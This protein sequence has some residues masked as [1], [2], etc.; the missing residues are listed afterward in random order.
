MFRPTFRRS[1]EGALILEDTSAA[2]VFNSLR[3]R[4]TGK[5][6]TPDDVRQDALK[7]VCRLGGNTKD[8]CDVLGCYKFQHSKYSGQTFKWMVENVLEYAVCFVIKMANEIPST[9]SLSINKFN[10]K[11]YLESF[12]EGKEAIAMKEIKRCRKCP[13]RQTSYIPVG[14]KLQKVEDVTDETLSGTDVFDAS[15]QPSTSYAPAQPNTSYEPVSTMPSTTITIK[16]S[17]DCLIPDKWK[18]NLP[19]IDQQ[20]ISKTLFKKSKKGTAELDSTKLKQL[21]YYPPQPDPLNKN[22]PMANSYFGHRLLLWLPRKTWQVKLVCPRPECKSYP[23]TSGGLHGIV[24]PVL[25]LDCHYFLATEQLRCSNCKQRQIGWSENIL[26]QLDLA[27]RLQFPVVLSYHLACDNRVLQLLKYRGLGNSPSQLR[28]QVLEQHTRRWNERV[29]LYLEN[30]KKFCG[31]RDDYV[32]AASKFDE[33]SKMIP[34][35]SVQWFL[36]IY[37][38][39][40]MGRIDELKASITSTFGRVLKIDSTKRIVRKLAGRACGTGAWATNV[41]NEYGQV[42]ITVLTAAEGCG[43]NNMTNGI[44]NRYALAGVPPPEILYVDRDCCGHSSIRKMFSAWPDMKIRLDIWHFMRRIAA[45]CST[46]S[47]QLYP[48]FLKR[49]SACI[50]EWSADDVELLKL[51]KREQLIASKK[52]SN[53][54][55][56]IILKNISKKEYALHCRRTTRGTRETANLIRELLTSL[57]GEEGRDTMGVPLLDSEQTWDIWSSQERHIA[58]IQDPEGI[59]LYTKTSEMLKGGVTL[60]VYRCARGSTSLESFHLHLNR[61]IPGERASDLHFQAYLMDGLVRWNANRALAA[62]QSG[63]PIS[64]TY[65]GLHQHALNILAEQVIGKKVYKSFIIPNKYTGEL[66]GVEYLY[67]QS[68]KVLE[69]QFPVKTDTIYDEDFDEEIYTFDVDEGY[70]DKTQPD[71]K[72]PK[73]CFKPRNAK[74]P[75]PPQLEPLPSCDDNDDD[76]QGKAALFDTELEDSTGP[77]NIPGYAKVEAMADY[78]MQFKED[79]GVISQSHAEH[80]AKLW[81]NLDAYDKTIKR[82]ARHQDYL[83]KG[84]FK[85]SKTT[86]VIPGVESTRRCFLGQN[87]GPAQWPDCNRYMECIITKLCEAYPSTVSIEGR[88]FQRWPLITKG[89]KNIRRKVLSNGHLML[90]AK[91]QLMEINRTTLIQWYNRTSK[92]QERQVLESGISAT[93]PKLVSDKTLLEPLTKPAVLNVHTSAPSFTFVLPKNTS[94]LATQGNRPSI[95]VPG[96]IA[97]PPPSVPEASSTRIPRTTLLYRKRVAKDISE[98]KPIKIYKPRTSAIVCSKCKQPRLNKNHTQYYGNWYCAAT[99]DVTFKEWKSAMVAIRRL[100]QER[101]KKQQKE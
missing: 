49:L 50:F 58:C 41:G 87:T 85:K 94:G 36:T 51:A 10:F 65:S 62:T 22:I 18:K 53:P 30:C 70:D 95:P 15:L 37:C 56:D 77:D 63:G 86:S 82:K 91:L 66:I 21:C 54:T 71:Y 13:T 24:R 98:G 20:W 28:Q 68:N 78:L 88:R 2:V 92:K 29:A 38:N 80:V 61:F 40:V 46:E 83:T 35:P 7:E 89:Y 90:F 48:I 8:E 75:S 11:R 6:L 57:D 72:P 45:A 23:L 26:K 9:S 97:K 64:S 12:P 32:I 5:C 93:I 43:L 76:G 81:N 16:Q 4:P 33:V 44:I 25:D 31:S 47:H 14:I 1:E 59:P 73:R 3:K 69:T 100:R 52:H 79:S 67:N 96:E 19:E 99:S 84:R 55:D 60:P 17:E 27:H 74:E 42:L 39:E 101:K 34:V